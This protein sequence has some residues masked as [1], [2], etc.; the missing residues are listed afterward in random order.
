[1]I[2]YDVLGN[3]ELRDKYIE[4]ALSTDE[5]DDEMIMFVRGL[6]DRPDL[7][8]VEVAERRLA[9]LEKQENWSQR[10]RALKVLERFVDAATD[11]IRSVQAS[12]GE[13][14]FFSAA[15][16]LKE[17]VESGLIGGLFQEALQDARERGDLWWQVRALQE[18]GRQ[19]ELT[20]LLLE[21]S[22]TIDDLKLD[23]STTAVM[24][25]ELLAAARGEDA[26]VEEFAKAEALLSTERLQSRRASISKQV[27][28]KA[29]RPRTRR[30]RTRAHTR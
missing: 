26:L 10:A 18:L 20:D 28:K 23:G 11:Y 8:P 5:A 4:V 21:N 13:G 15:Y 27:V 2:H 14:R 24:L 3:T 22:S 12:L 30:P 1:V 17:L 19:D 6:Q 29:A 16:Y 7:I 25:K 9:Q